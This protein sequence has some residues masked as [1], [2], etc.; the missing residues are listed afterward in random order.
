[1]KDENLEKHL[2]IAVF[3]INK[4]IQPNGYSVF[5]IY[6]YQP[7]EMLESEIKN[8]SM[9]IEDEVENYLYN[10]QLIYN[11]IYSIETL[12]KLKLKDGQVYKENPFKK[13]QIILVRKGVKED[14]HKW[15]VK[16]ERPST[17][18]DTD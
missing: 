15:D 3:Y 4:K 2:E 17:I 16:N 10:K 6:T 1:M 13:K 18:I 12:R 8:T 7:N 11:Y 5:Q 9:N 14:G